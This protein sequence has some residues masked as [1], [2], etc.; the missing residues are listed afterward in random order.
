[1]ATK[2]YAKSGEYTL[3]DLMTVAASREVQD[4]EVVFAGTGMPM[5]A[6]LLAQKTHAPNLKLIFEAGTLDGRPSCL[7]T[8]VGDAR[9]EM[10]ASRA[11]GLTEAFSIAQR[12]YVDLGF[13]GGAEVDEYGNVNTTV[14]GDYSAPS[15]RLTGSGG[16]PDINSF[17]KRTVFIMVHEPRRFTKNVSYITSPGWRVKKWPSG[18]WVHRRELY[19]GSFRGGPSAV[20]STAGVFRFDQETGRMYLDTC[21]PGKTPEEIKTMCQFDLDISRN[22]GETA[23]P[24]YEELHIIHDILDPEE[25]FLPK[26]KKVEAPVAPAMKR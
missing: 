5:I 12:G 19:G 23:P 9:C 11:S 22:R 26:P 15:L 13:L 7:P 4:N 25:I 16:N 1:M 20:I 14:I 21:H 3:A 10:G 17:A 18:E 6:I 2:D 24:N 8:S